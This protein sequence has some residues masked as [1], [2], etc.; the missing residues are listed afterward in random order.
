M[1]L[2]G[3]GLGIMSSAS[4][5]EA[6]Q[7]AR[8]PTLETAPVTI[9]G[10]F[11]FH[12]RGVSAYTAEDRAQ[13]VTQRIVDTARNPA[14][15]RE[16]ILVKALADRSDIVAGNSLILSIFDVD[17]EYEGVE[18]PL[19]VEAILQQIRDAVDQ[20]RRDRSPK[21]LTTY[22]AYA[23]ATTV[24]FAVVLVVF[25]LFMRFLNRFAA[26][27][28][29]KYIA[30][31]EAK[32]SRIVRA[33][34]VWKLLHAILRTLWIIIF[35]ILAYGYLA[36]LLGLFPWTRALS[37]RLSG[38][39]GD[40]LLTVGVAILDA[41]PDLLLVAILIL[42]TRYVLKITRVFFD[43][44][45]DGHLAIRRFLAGMGGSHLQDRPPGDRGIRVL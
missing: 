6:A 24:G 11:L 37:V 7:P 23:L 18:R 14:I 3:A 34:Q 42:L 44:V 38:L 21:S 27:R 10:S 2:V 1:L 35:V 12:L 28:H 36:Y 39:V 16:M 40:R 19:L 20:Y 29:L 5:Q 33:D 31:L 41:L 43:A 22:A 4:A 25:F 45:R 9:D 8:P 15:T 13:V 30:P 17:A 32:S 26:A